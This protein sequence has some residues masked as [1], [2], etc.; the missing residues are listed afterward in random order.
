[1]TQITNRTGIAA[2]LQFLKNWGLTF[3]QAY[4]DH[5]NRTYLKRHEE[6]CIDAFQAISGKKACF[7]VDVKVGLVQIRAYIAQLEK[8]KAF[9]PDIVAK[10]FETIA[11]IEKILFEP[12]Q[13]SL[14]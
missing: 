4:A 3:R 13:L 8:E 11:S 10:H 14:L 6:T 9:A 12:K 7:G 2:E 5:P 1:M